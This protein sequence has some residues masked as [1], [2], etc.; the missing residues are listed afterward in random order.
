MPHAAPFWAP[1]P[2]VFPSLAGHGWSRHSSRSCGCSASQSTAPDLRRSC[3]TSPKTWWRP[4][5]FTRVGEAYLKHCENSRESMGKYDP[6]SI[7]RH[8]ISG[9]ADNFNGKMFILNWNGDA[10]INQNCVYTDKTCMCPSNPKMMSFES[11]NLPKWW[12]L[13]PKLSYKIVI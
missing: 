12:C 13:N 9:K 7:L 10:S 4:L 6:S 8:F 3:C 1:A 2:A 5:G 11:F